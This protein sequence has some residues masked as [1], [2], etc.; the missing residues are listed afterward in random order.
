MSNTDREYDAWLYKDV[1]T[2]LV[3]AIIESKKP[4]GSR[5]EQLIDLA[6]RTDVTRIGI[7]H[8]VGFAE[9][10]EK[11]EALLGEHF[12]VVSV[13]CRIHDLQAGDVIPGAEGSLCNPAGQ[14]E[15]LNDAETELNVSVGLC[16]GHDMI[17]QDHSEAPVTV[18]AVKD[19]ATDHQPLK[20][21]D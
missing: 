13:S 9:E 17:F 4:G 1:Y 7:A 10:A 15:A 14:A 2:D 19:R 3:G 11:L 8:C 20:A 21:L 5:I 16:L 18:M 6:K 12:E